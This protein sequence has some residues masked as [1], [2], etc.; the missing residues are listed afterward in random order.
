MSDIKFLNREISSHEQR[1]ARIRSTD[2]YNLS[3]QTQER[4]VR[5]FWASLDLMM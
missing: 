2:M 3:Q 1:N 5:K 4:V